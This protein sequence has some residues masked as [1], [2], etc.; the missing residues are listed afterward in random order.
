MEKIIPNF[1]PVNKMIK[2]YADHM[3]FS[4]PSA[5]TSTAHGGQCH[6]IYPYG[7]KED[8][9]IF[10]EHFF[11]S[12][13]YLS[14]RINEHTLDP[15]WVPD[16]GGEPQLMNMFYRQEDKLPG[17][18][19][20]FKEYIN[21]GKTYVMSKV[22]AA[23]C[24]LQQLGVP[25]EKAGLSGIWRSLFGKSISGLRIVGGNKI[26]SE[27]QYGRFVVINGLELDFPTHTTWKEY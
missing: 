8:E 16:G 3:D 26:F 13:E 5:Y 1:N 17:I 14:W 6:Q 11:H 18:M 15:E 2:L 25:P 19:K 24:E 21:L 9:D 4:K 22:L 23:I 20:E 10:I 12:D 27:E 7:S